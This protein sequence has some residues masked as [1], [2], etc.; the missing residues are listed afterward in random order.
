MELTL[1]VEKSYRKPP[2][3]EQALLPEAAYKPRRNKEKHTQLKVAAFPGQTVLPVTDGKGQKW[4]ATLSKMS[5]R[6]G[7]EAGTT[8]NDE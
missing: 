4:M 1:E 2:S 8:T 6:G 7:G 5:P 3:P